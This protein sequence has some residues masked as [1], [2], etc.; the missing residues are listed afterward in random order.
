MKFC[1]VCDN[2]LYIHTEDSQLAFKCKNCDFAES[3]TNNGSVLISERQVDNPA[4]VNLNNYLTTNIKYDPSLPHVNNIRCPNCVEKED[5]V[6]YIKYDAKN[7][8]YLYLCC[9]CD[10][11]WTLEHQHLGL[12][13]EAA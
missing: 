5:D 6:I 9:K 4:A 10:H 1:P 3:P 13:I 12:K 8:K 11:F 7:M 2:M